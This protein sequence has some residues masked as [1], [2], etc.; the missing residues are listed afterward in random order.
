MAVVNDAFTPT[1]DEVNWATEVLEAFDRA[2]SQG[3]GVTVLNGRL[4]DL[5]VVLR[6][7][8]TLEVVAA[9]S[10]PPVA[11]QTSDNRGA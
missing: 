7:R 11:A 6:A 2:Q 3:S 9:A 8:R 1:A 10:E 5:P 4:V